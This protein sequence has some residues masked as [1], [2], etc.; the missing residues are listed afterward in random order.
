MS[1]WTQTGRELF[2]LRTELHRL[3][4]QRKRL[5][6]SLGDAA[7]RADIREVDDEV[8]ACER[9][10]VAAKKR[11]RRQEERQRMT[12]RPTRQLR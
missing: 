5:H 6:F 8:A 11:A 4:A 2:G 12:I 9:R 10:V 3:R 7:Y 1:I